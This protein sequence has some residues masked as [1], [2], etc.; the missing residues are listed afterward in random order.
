MPKTTSKATAP[1][2]QLK[3]TLRDSRPPIWRRV[4]VPGDFTLFK[5]HY[6]IQAAFGWLDYH[7]HQ[8]IIDGSYYSIPS[9]EDWEPIIDERRFTLQT[10]APTPGKKF[11]YE[12]DFGDSWEHNILV[13]KI[14]PAEPSTTY[15]VCVKGKRACP[16]ED[17]GGIWGY[18]NFLEAIADPAHEEHDSYLE[19]VGG[20]FDPEEFDL[21]QINK[22]LKQVK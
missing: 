6:V 20:E 14:I 16:P 22:L 19:W 17:V 13:E 11:T 1:I 15:P 4:L 3:I 7:L 12:Y 9:P 21:E 2:Y 5:L 10:I 8:F 18:A